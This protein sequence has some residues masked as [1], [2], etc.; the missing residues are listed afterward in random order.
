VNLDNLREQ[1]YS[2]AADKPLFGGLDVVKALEFC[3][4]RQARSSPVRLFQ[5]S[6][7]EG[8]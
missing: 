3:A 4:D 2:P 7:T 5:G 6:H 1:P 8:V